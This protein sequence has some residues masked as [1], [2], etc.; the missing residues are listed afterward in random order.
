MINLINPSSI[1]QLEKEKN[2]AKKIKK[3]LF[4]ILK[5]RIFKLGKFRASVK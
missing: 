4:K 5:K 1:L 2:T 3:M